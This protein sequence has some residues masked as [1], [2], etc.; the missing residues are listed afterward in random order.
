MMME[1]MGKGVEEVDVDGYLYNN[2][3]QHGW[4]QLL[5]LRDM[6]RAILTTLYCRDGSSEADDYY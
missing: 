5:R 4:M 2:S 6:S 3:K 1:L